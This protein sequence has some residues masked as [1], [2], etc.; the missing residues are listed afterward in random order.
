[1]R[2]DSEHTTWHEFF[3][4]IAMM[5]A[6]RSKDPRCQNGTCIVKDHIILGVGYNGFVNGVQDTEALWEREKKHSYVVHSERNALYN[7]SKS[8]EGADLYLWSSGL[9]LPCLECSK[10]I[11]QA[12]IKEVF[13]M[14]EP[15]AEVGARYNWDEALELLDLVNIPVTVLVEPKVTTQGILNKAKHM[16]TPNSHPLENK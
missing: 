11:A 13:L 8:P 2:P 16:C 4:G 5:A 14:G 6:T 10:S 1:M 7:C 9:Y 3:F 12:G 15:A